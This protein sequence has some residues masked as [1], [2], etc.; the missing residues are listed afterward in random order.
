MAK[1]LFSTQAKTYAQYRPH[2]PQELFAHLFSL[3]RE[4]GKAWDCATGNG[5]AAVVLAEQFAKVEATDIS[6]TQL[7]HAVQKPNIQYSIAAAEQTSFPENSFDLITVAQAYHWLDWNAFKT[8]AKRVGKKNCLVAIW[9]YNRFTTGDMKLDSLFDHFYHDITGPYWDTERKYVDA[10]YETV[11][12]DFA[13][14]DSHSFYTELQ[15]TREQVIGYFNSW[16]AVQKYI[17]QHGH[18]PVGLIE[19]ELEKI[20]GD[21][22]TYTLRFSIY[23]KHGRIIK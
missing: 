4:K 15:W 12:F 13:E 10:N 23:L 16:S 11:D 19:E 3:V 20:W 21:K 1:D 17:S 22:E 14:V 9:T 18:T 8:E 5:Q 6:K 2:Y 7:R